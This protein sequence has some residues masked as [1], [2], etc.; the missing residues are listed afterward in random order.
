MCVYR[1]NSVPRLCCCLAATML[2]FLGVSV[3][4]GDFINTAALV[5]NAVC[6][7]NKGCRQGVPGAS[8]LCCACCRLEWSVRL[9]R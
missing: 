4:G 9:G 6:G 5:S 1:I 3:V 8:R 7:W 2:L